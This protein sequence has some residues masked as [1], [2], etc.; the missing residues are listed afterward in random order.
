MRR[1]MLDYAAAMARA[2]GRLAAEE[3]A[4]LHEVG[5]VFGIAASDVEKSAGRV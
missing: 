1:A 2:N 4:Y 5:V 3:H